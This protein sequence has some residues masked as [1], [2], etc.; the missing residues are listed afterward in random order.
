M[1]HDRVSESRALAGV[2]GRVPTPRLERIPPKNSSA[3]SLGAAESG[4]V[5]ELA[6]AGAQVVSLAPEA[7]S[8]EDV[9][10]E[11]VS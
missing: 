6:R 11:V 3:D 4:L 7:P 8:L 2:S 10:L 5:A 1:D 9:F